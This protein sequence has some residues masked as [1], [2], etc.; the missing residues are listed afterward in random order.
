[1][2]AKIQKRPLCDYLNTSKSRKWPAHE[3]LLDK[4][5]LNWFEGIFCVMRILQLSRKPTVHGKQRLFLYIRGEMKPKKFRY[6]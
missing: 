6:V 4:K 2:S 5:I 3:C 1:M